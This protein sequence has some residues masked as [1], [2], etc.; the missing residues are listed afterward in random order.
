MKKMKKLVALIIATA[1]VLSMMSIAAFAADGDPVI[2]VPN[3]DTHTY[4]V[5]Q[6]FTGKLDGTT[7][8]N[9]MWGQNGTG[10]GQVD[11]T[12]LDAIAALSGSDADKAAALA[13][14]AN[15]ESTPIIP[16]LTK[17]TD[18]ADRTVAPG[19]YLI[20]DRDDVTLEEGD[21]HTLYIVQVVNELYN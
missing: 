19:Y 5:Y 6:I 17:D 12:T 15:L 20:K 1:M 21:E 4:E 13:A 8:S 10:T 7:L 11:K 2:S 3:E 9:V 14:Y 18:E 16:S